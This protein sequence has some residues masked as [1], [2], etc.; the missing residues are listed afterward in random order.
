MAR[1]TYVLTRLHRR[2][3]HAGLPRDVMLGA[4]PSPVSHGVGVPK[5]PS[6]AFT[7]SS[8]PATDEVQARFVAFEP[9]Q[10][11]MPC[12]ATFR[13]RWGKRWESKA[14]ASRAV[15]IAIDLMQKSREPKLLLEA[16]EQPLPELGL[17]PQRAP[18]APVSVAPVASS[19]GKDSASCALSAHTTGGMR[20]E[21]LLLLA[22]A[23][24]AP[25]AASD[26]RVS[27]LVRPRGAGR[28][29]K[30]SPCAR[31]GSRA[32]WKAHFNFSPPRANARCRIA[33]S[34]LWR[35]RS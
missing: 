14:R 22:G 13:F 30:R 29:T 10:R 20:F 5:G 12:A 8:A 3:A 19:G 2:Y 4:A 34:H 1:Q 35:F 33:R 31:T 23:L 7:P 24:L 27:F 6:H 16:L 15:P 21:A 32:L 11:E 26:R 17:V 18:A 28:P 25:G 9:W